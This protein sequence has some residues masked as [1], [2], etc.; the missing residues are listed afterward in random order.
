[1]VTIQEIPE[2][3]H[4]LGVGLSLAAK[5]SLATRRGLANGI[6]NFK[7]PARQFDNVRVGERPIDTGQF[8]ID[9]NLGL[10]ELSNHQSTHTLVELCMLFCNLQ[11]TEDEIA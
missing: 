11:T 9:S 1:M 10:P 3:T 2:S 7:A 6:A 5:P 8:M 4:R